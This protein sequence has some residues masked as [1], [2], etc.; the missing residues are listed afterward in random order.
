MTHAI[1]F[2]PPDPGH[3]SYSFKNWTKRHTCPVCSRS[4]KFNQ[5]FLG[6]R[7]VMCDGVKFTKVDRAP[8]TAAERA[9]RR[10]DALLKKPISELTEDEVMEVAMQTEDDGLIALARRELKIRGAIA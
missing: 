9:E 7:D 3:A 8:R 2:V 1:A 4:G 6:G 5:N 10:L